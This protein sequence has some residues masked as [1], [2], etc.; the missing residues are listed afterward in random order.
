MFKES[1]TEQSKSPVKF[2]TARSV[3]LTTSRLRLQMRGHK[4]E[5]I[6]YQLEH[7]LWCSKEPSQ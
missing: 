4:Y 7:M 5:F 3:Y 1:M 6:S 2:A